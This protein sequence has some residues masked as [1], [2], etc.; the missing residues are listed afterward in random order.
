MDFGQTEYTDEATGEQITLAFPDKLLIELASSNG[1]DIE[2][3]TTPNV[4]NLL[5]ILI[6]KWLDGSVQTEELSSIANF[7]LSIIKYEGEELTNALLA[8]S[9]LSYYIRHTNSES[10]EP[11]HGFVA[12]LKAYYAKSSPNT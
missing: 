2:H 11:L 10:G 1:I 5:H 7:L 6:G 3:L 4:E 12:D 9:E 8:A